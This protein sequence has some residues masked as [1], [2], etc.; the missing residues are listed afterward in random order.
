MTELITRFKRDMAL[1]AFSPRTIAVYTSQLDAY[2]QYYQTNPDPFTSEQM[3]DYLYYLLEKKKL[4]NSGIRQCYGALKFYCTYTGD[5]PWAMNSLPQSKKKRR[6]PT[7]LTIQETSRLLK[8]AANLK[9]QTM[10]TLIYSSGLRVSELPPLVTND[11]QR[12]GMKLLVREAKGGKDR[13][14]VLSQHCLT[15]LETY[16]KAYRPKEYLFPGRGGKTRLSVRACQHAFELAKAKAAIS[17]KGGIPTLRHSF[18][19]PALEGGMGIFQL[20]KMLGHK[21]LK[22]TLGYVHLSE[23]KI[24]V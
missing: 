4:S 1:R 7:V 15:L 6:L 20:Q 24:L 3:K 9:H 13:Y 22:T 17:K 14:T 21:N 5:L 12:T 2:L 16:W 23:E 18:A 11:I 8:A 10:L 19:T